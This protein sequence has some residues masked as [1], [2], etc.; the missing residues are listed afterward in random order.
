[1]GERGGTVSG[2][3]PVVPSAPRG[4]KDS[5]PH[6]TCYRRCTL[7][8]FESPISL[9]SARHPEQRVASRAGQCDLDQYTGRHVKPLSNVGIIVRY[10]AHASAVSD[11]TA[12]CHD[13]CIRVQLLPR[14]VQLDGLRLLRH[15][16]RQEYGRMWNTAIIR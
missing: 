6:L 13:P 4:E 5:G 12:S 16:N 15:S 11:C 10:L 9:C 2:S 8:R 14:R 3:G 7:L 1:M